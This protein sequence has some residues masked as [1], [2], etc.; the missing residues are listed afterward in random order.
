MWSMVLGIEGQN[1]DKCGVAARAHS[2]VNYPHVH[3]YYTSIPASG[4]WSP[5]ITVHWKESA[6]V[7]PAMPHKV[8]GA[9]FGA[10]KA[11]RAPAR[12]RL[13][14][15]PAPPLRRSG[16]VRAKTGFPVPM[17]KNLI[18]GG[19]WRVKRSSSTDKAI[20]VNDNEQGQ[21]MTNDQGKCCSSQHL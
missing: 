18:T 20:T 17:G 15:S 8:S 11:R 10:K 7:R 2:C 9:E 3:V 16:A 13:L 5:M 21:T 19:E 1:G 12:R 4:I 14:P 6:R